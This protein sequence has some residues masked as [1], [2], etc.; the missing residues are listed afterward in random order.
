[1]GEFSLT[2]RFCAHV[3]CENLLLA[4]SPFL[5][6][7]SQRYL[8]LPWKALTNSNHWLWLL[9]VSSYVYLF[10]LFT[11]L[12]LCLCVCLYLFGLGMTPQAVLKTMS[13]N[14]RRTRWRYQR[15]QSS[16]GRVGL[17]TNAHGVLMV[18]SV[19]ECQVM[20]PEEL[21]FEVSNLYKHVGFHIMVESTKT[22]WVG[23][24]MT[25]MKAQLQVDIILTYSYVTLRAIKINQVHDHH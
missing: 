19:D 24:W 8:V 10:F 14:P 5:Q 2:P 17:A 11:Y 25:D 6:V 9:H 16:T 3:P 20:K 7:R 1:M 23:T 4:D 21:N 22:L 18:F 13:E 15:A 12:F